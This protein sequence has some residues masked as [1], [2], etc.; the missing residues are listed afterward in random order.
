MSSICVQQIEMLTQS[1]THSI[2]HTFE[3]KMPL[4]LVPPEL[5]SLLW[6]HQD[7]VIRHKSIPTFINRYLSKACLHFIQ[8][9]RSSREIELK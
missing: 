3:F 1:V 8:H 9:A 2:T 6:L 5:L 4:H 7:N